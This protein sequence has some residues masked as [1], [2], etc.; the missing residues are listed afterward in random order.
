MK[1][2]LKVW[3]LVW[4]CGLLCVASARGQ[5]VPDPV[6]YRQSVFRLMA[7]QSKQLGAMVQGRKP[8]DQ[9]DF[10]L[11]AQRLDW[12]SGMLH[13]AFEQP[14]DSATV[15]GLK[16]DMWY[17]KERFNSYLQGLKQA[18]EALAK[19]AETAQRKDELR[20]GYGQLARQCKGC[21]DRFRASR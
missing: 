20:R 18:T 15:T 4:G 1:K 2:R 6:S 11:R 21:H 8:Y 12:L 13:E 19:Q 10:L 14:A 3:L 9:A 7:W 17:Q 5:E 16:P